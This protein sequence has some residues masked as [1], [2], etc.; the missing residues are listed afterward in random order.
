M[1]E[2]WVQS[3]G[4]EDPLEKIKATDSSILAWTIPWIVWGHKEL[5]TTERLSLSFKNTHETTQAMKG[6]HIQKATK[7]LKNV[8]LN[9]FCAIPSLQWC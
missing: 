3:L 4:W 5:Y 8:T 6:M 9:I 1:W 7:Y 2:T